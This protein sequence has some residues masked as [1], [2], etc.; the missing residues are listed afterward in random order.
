MCFGDVLCLKGGWVISGEHTCLFCCLGKYPAGSALQNAYIDY[1]DKDHLFDLAE[2]DFRILELTALM[3]A[4]KH[5]E[6]RA[7]SEHFPF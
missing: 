6:G 4:R 1:L 3:S 5:E 7:K 2:E